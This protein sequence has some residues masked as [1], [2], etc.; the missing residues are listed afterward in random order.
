MLNG[1]SFLLYAAS[2]V[3]VAVAATVIAV[4]AARIVGRKLREAIPPKRDVEM[5]TANMMILFQSMRDILRQQKELAAEINE[6]VEKKVA[7]IDETVERALGELARVQE[8]Q[9][10]LAVQLEDAQSDLLSLRRRLG[11]DVADPSART[12][13]GNGVRGDMP[14]EPLPH[15]APDGP[16]YEIGVVAPASESSDEGVDTWVGLDFG[17]VDEHGSAGFD[18]PEVA[19]AEPDDPETAREAFRA[20]LDMPATPASFDDA[21][22]QRGPTEPSGANGA[23]LHS[24][25]YEYTDAGMSVHQIARELGI[26]KGE[27]RLILSLRKDRDR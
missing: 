17:E 26:G 8:T 10:Q 22:P 5:D 11:E 19:P 2:G 21:E 1:S 14:S 18:V 6:S 4:L 9:R 23:A 24:R 15:R 25:V 13:S 7:Y 12:A 16:D 3:A 20:L 27:V